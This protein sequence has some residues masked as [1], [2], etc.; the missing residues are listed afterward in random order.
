MTETDWHLNRFQF[1]Y[2][3]GIGYRVDRVLYDPVCKQPLVRDVEKQAVFV[4]E[5]DAKFYCAVRNAALKNLRFRRRRS[6]RF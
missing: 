5:A 4:Y 1:C 3:P 6:Y 2:E